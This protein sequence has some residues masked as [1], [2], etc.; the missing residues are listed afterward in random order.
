MSAKPLDSNIF[1][2]DTTRFPKISVNDVER[3]ANGPGK[4]KFAV[5][6]SGFQG[7]KTMGA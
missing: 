4:V 5:S 1:V 2:G 6:A 3:G 7:S